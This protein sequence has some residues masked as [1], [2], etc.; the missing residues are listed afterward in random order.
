MKL[1]IERSSGPAETVECQYKDLEPGQWFFRLRDL[2]VKPKHTG[3]QMY[4]TPPCCCVST[5]VQIHMY[6][7]THVTLVHSADV[8]VVV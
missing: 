5:G 4:H 1:N 8:E 2:Y 6:P 7:D 3:S